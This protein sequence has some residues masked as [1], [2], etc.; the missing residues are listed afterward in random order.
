[1]V[2]KEFRAGST[3][4]QDVGLGEPSLKGLG[5]E[6]REEHKEVHLRQKPRRHGQLLQSQ[7][8]RGLTYVLKDTDDHNQSSLQREMEVEVRMECD[9]ILNNPD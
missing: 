1:M 3:E 2:W 4:V 8:R 5:E 9:S 7:A 6:E